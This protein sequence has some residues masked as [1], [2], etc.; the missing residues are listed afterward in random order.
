MNYRLCAVAAAVVLSG[1]SSVRLAVEADDRVYCSPGANPPLTQSLVKSSNSSAFAS[2][3]LSKLQS[4]GNQNLVLSYAQLVGSSQAG[5]A[6]A[7]KGPLPWPATQSE[8]PLQW[9][10]PSPAHV[11]AVT[12]G[13]S[14][15]FSLTGLEKGKDSAT[16]SQLT[17][18]SWRQ[19]NQL[20]L[21]L[22]PFAEVA[23]RT[24]QNLV[25]SLASEGAK[26]RS[27]VPVS[28]TLTLSGRDD[29]TRQIVTEVQRGGDVAVEA[30]T[31]KVAIDALSVLALSEKGGTEAEVALAAQRV[32]E[33]TA[34]RF[35]REYLKAYFR[36][37]KPFQVKA[38]TGSFA[39]VAIEKMV[40]KMTP[41]PTDQQKKE[42]QDDVNKA[43][44][45][46][47]KVSP[48][49]GCLMTSPLGGESFVSRSGSSYQFEGLTM[50]VSYQGGIKYAVD[51]PK[52]SEA[53]PQI[54]R[55]MVEALFD[56]KL[57]RTPAVNTSTACVAGIYGDGICMDVNT[58]EDVKQAVIKTDEDAAK[59]DSLA[60]A[61]TGYLIRGLSFVALNNEAV[62]RS[63][64]NFGAV[65]ARKVTERASWKNSV[66][67]ACVSPL[68]PVQWSVTK[69]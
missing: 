44:D 5:Q 19:A 25:E 14:L 61:A 28:Q 10:Q 7:F 64:E 6:S 30:L 47:C 13:E 58:P 15:L 23:Y 31:Y 1:C 59:A 24:D 50:N 53:A 17:P 21:K 20:W 46:Q 40:A 54:V 63:V 65:F 41:T 26:G 57:P 9:S 43:L 32:A 69:D 12:D 42:W 11:A 33:Y 34:V 22:A 67:N 18:A 68:T 8:Q 60:G 4:S 27:A 3:R 66:K 38:D 51:H 16:V 55:V 49:A 36:G 39:K 48:E 45:E 29:W 2:T 52:T 62:A 56:A 35:L 37:G